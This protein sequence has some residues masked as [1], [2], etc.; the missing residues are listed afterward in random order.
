MADEPPYERDAPEQALG[1]SFLKLIRQ[2]FRYRRFNGE[3]SG[4][5]EHE[6]LRRGD[7]AAILLYD[8]TIDAVILVTQF[9]LATTY[10]NSG[11][12]WLIEL[13]AGEVNV[14][15]H[16]ATAAL[17]EAE[18]ETGYK[19]SDCELITTI[20]PSAGGSSEKIHIYF[21]RVNAS[22]RVGKGGGVDGEEVVPFPVTL[23]CL[24][25]MLDRREITDAKLLVAAQWMRSSAK[26][27]AQS[28]GPL[29]P[30]KGKRFGL[31]VGNQIRYIGYE[32][33]DIS[34]IARPID[35]W[36]NSENTDMLMAR[37]FEPAIS[38]SIRYLGAAK[39]PNGEV[40]E[41]TIAEAL[42][43]KLAGQIFVRPG[44]VIGTDAGELLRTHGVRL[45]LHAAA[46]HAQRGYGEWGHLG[47]TEACVRKALLEI[48]GRNQHLLRW[49]RIR[50]SFTSVLFPLLGTGNGRQPTGL[51]AQKIVELA[52][53]H[54]L[55][56]ESK[57]NEIYLCAFNAADRDAIE[58]AISSHADLKPCN[59]AGGN[60]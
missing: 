10:G 26:Q 15:E 31:K 16:P 6:V 13:P 1:G 35:V 57:L 2:N 51:V 27:S 60:A 44:E 9:R 20:Y 38:G 7:S 58:A 40:R 37:F 49:M 48:E 47:F 59:P 56:P 46:V 8:E 23:P 42:R 25:G 33:G 52:R 34:G 29:P 4:E 11:D 36:V 53:H 32:T 24:W 21:A 19:P 39:Y 18:E 45:L 22:M 54:L 17:R 55:K 41:D 12:G 30:G 43:A 50:R 28:Q 5:L 3:M 14:G